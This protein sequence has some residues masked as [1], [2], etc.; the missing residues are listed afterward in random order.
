[1]LKWEG[2]ATDR[3]EVLFRS[4]KARVRDVGGELRRLATSHSTFQLDGGWFVVGPTGL[5]VVA[6]GEPDLGTAARWA[7]DRATAMRAELADQLVWVPFVDAIVAT[8]HSGPGTD[9]PCL[10]V[11]VSL[12]RSTIE[13][14]PRTVDDAT[15]SKLGLLAMRRLP[16]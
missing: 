3:R 4:A 5:F 10:V 2:S 9:L 8:S 11:P 16:G 15:L 7:V 14:G 1:V 13:D 6:A 12:L